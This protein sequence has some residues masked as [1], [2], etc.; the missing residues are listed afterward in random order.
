MAFYSKAVT[1]SR[2]GVKGM[3]R[4]RNA[5]ASKIALLIA[6]GVGPCTASPAPKLGFRRS[7][8]SKAATR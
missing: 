8:R 7:N 3:S 4:I 2:S 5:V 6:A 1:R